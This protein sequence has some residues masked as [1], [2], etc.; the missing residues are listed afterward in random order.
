MIP[1]SKTYRAITFILGIITSIFLLVGT[2]IDFQVEDAFANDEIPIVSANHTN[3]NTIE[4][5][6]IETN[7]NESHMLESNFIASFI[8]LL[9]EPEN[10]ELEETNESPDI[11]A[12][13]KNLFTSNE[14]ASSGTIVN[15]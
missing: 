5:Q 1:K 10:E 7:E 2:D 12:A 9:S 6:E 13:I 11:F 4:I 8:S 3:Q 14:N 15:H